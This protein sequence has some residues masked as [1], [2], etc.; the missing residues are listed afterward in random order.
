MRK[1]R[2]LSLCAGI[3]GADLAAEWTNQI[4][5]V[6]QVEINPFCQRVLATHWPRVKRVGDIREVQGDEF[7]T[8]DIIVGGI[9]CQPFSSAGKQRGAEDDRYLWP[10]MF[11]LVTRAHPAWVV[12]ENVDDLTYL[13]LDDVSADLESQGYTVQ[14][15]VLPACS[16]G[17]PHLRQ[18][19]FVVAHHSGQRSGAW[20]PESAGQQWTAN[21]HS[22]GSSDVADAQY[23]GCEWG[24]FDAIQSG[25]ALLCRRT[26]TGAESQPRMGRVFHGISARLDSARWLSLRGVTPQEWEPAGVVYGKISERRKRIEALGNAIVPYQIYPFFAGIVEWERAWEKDAA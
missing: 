20:W 6:G 2:M 18:R 10:E 16:V 1:L 23:G 5:V 12:L 9:P 4:E 11:R 22:S 26:A 13:A 17:A 14:A 8:I 3:G 24:L 25:A 7:G 19:C 15:F 21:A